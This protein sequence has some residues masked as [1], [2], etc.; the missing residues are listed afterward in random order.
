MDF[1][2]T[3]L[4][5]EAA[6]VVDVDVSVLLDHEAKIANG[7]ALRAEIRPVPHSACIR[8]QKVSSIHAMTIAYKSQMSKSFFGNLAL[9]N[10][11][12]PAF[13][14]HPPF[15]KERGDGKGRCTIQ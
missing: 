7:V 3:V 13:P 6:L 11:P 2:D 12:G 1:L 8:N 9:R 5:E 14:S 10:S 15:P 4:R